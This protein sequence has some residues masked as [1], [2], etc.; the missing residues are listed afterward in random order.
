MKSGDSLTVCC[1]HMVHWPVESQFLK[2]IIQTD[3]LSGFSSFSLIIYLILADY[4]CSQ[5]LINF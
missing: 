2:Q 4:I 3:K 1:V 5:F